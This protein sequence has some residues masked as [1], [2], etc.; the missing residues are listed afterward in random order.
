MSAPEG[1]YSA[2]LAT[3][4]LREQDLADPVFVR[5][6]CAVLRALGYGV[7]APEELDRLH[8]RLVDAMSSRDGHDRSMLWA[9]VGGGLQAYIERTQ[10]RATF[11]EPAP[12]EASPIMAGLVRDA[13][14]E[15]DRALQDPEAPG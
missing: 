14:R 3:T 9:R 10:G 11:G 1:S 6:L 5:A 15:V 2:A 4:G 7:I 8:L 13:A 12:T